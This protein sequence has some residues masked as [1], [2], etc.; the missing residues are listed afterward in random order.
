MVC[1]TCLSHFVILL[2]FEAVRVGLVEFSFCLQFSWHAVFKVARRSTLRRWI[3]AEHSAPEVR[4]KQI[5]DGTYSYVY[6]YGYVERVSSL[7]G[8]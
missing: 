2:G 3:H 7:L 5:Y 4:K 1:E 8:S 6:S